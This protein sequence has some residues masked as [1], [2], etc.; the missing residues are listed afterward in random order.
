ML[1]KD[2][3]EKQLS[4][5]PLYAF[6]FITPSELEFSSKVRW[7]CENECPMYGTSWA[8]PPGVGTV[9]ACV[10]KCRQYGNCL[11]IS[12]AAEVGD[13]ANITETLATRAEHERITDLVGGL[14]DQQ[15]LNPYILSTQSCSI[16]DCCAYEKGLQCRHIEEMHPCIE[17]HCINLIPTLEQLGEEIKYG[18]NT[19]FWYS[20]LFF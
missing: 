13:I 10:K 1:N 20:L 17:S 14:L 11:V 3:L 2:M 7:V 6:Y 19:V 9:D 18:G 8:C 15:G 16:C 12:T 4:E 5:L